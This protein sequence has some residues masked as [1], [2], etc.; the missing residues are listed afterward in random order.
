MLIIHLLINLAAV[1]ASY[2]SSNKYGSTG[3]PDN[4]EVAL[5]DLEPGTKLSEY[6]PL[7]RNQ[8]SSDSNWSGATIT[9][10]WVLLGVFSVL[11]DISAI[12]TGFMGRKDC[13]KPC[14]SLDHLND[15][16]KA[17]LSCGLVGSLLCFISSCAL[18]TNGARDNCTT[19]GIPAWS[20][21]KSLILGLALFSFWPSGEYRQTACDVSIG[22]AIAELAMVF[23][24]MSPKLCCDFAS[25]MACYCA[26]D[27]IIDSIAD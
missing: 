6:K 22:I 27:S 19:T 18:C 3:T 14:D 1:F 10:I 20:I 7:V 16:T 4:G 15:F 24:M 17:A 12:T 2:T 21:L 5:Y 26:I 25:D 11:L 23:F 13:P 9:S 8:V